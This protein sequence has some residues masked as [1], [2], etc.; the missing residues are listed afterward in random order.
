MQVTGKLAFIIPPAHNSQ[1]L[2][3]P[4]VPPSPPPFFSSLPKRDGRSRLYKYSAQGK[5]SGSGE[6]LFRLLRGQA[7]RASAGRAGSLRSGVAGGGGPAA[8]PAELPEPRTG[9]QSC[10]KSDGVGCVRSGV[11]APPA[12]SDAPSAEAGPRAVRAGRCNPV[13]SA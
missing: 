8:R 1:Q 4:R 12:C 6:V 10:A 2:S 9:V 11:G 7:R 13:V 5:P 3:C